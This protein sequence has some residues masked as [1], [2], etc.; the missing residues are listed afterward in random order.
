MQVIRELRNEKLDFWIKHNLNVLLIG[1]YGAGKTARIL[2]AFKRNNLKFKYFSAAT[3]DPWCDF[4]GIP[5]VMTDEN[6]AYLDYILP[7][8][9]RDDTIEAIYMDE[10]NRSHKKV[11]NAVME[12][13]QFKTINGRPFKNLKMIWAAI[14]PEEEGEYQVEPID[15]AQKDRFQVQIGVPYEPSLDY[16]ISKFEEK[17]ARAAISWWKDLTAEQQM[18]VS[19]R[20]LEYA[21]EMYNLPGGSIKDVLP[22]SSNP[23]KLTTTLKLGP[24][25]DRLCE[26]FAAND[27]EAAKK[28]LQIE[29]NYASGSR[30]FCDDVPAKVNKKDWMLFYLAVI[31]S[32]KLTALMNVNETAFN[33][34]LENCGTN[35]LFK[36]IINDILNTGTDKRLIKRI[37]KELRTNQELLTTLDQVSTVADKAYFGKKVSNI[38]WDSR[39]SAWISKPMDTTPNRVAIYNEILDSLPPNLTQTEAVNTLE[40]LSLIASRSHA[41][42]LKK[43]HHLV[44]A[45]NHCVEQ[46]HKASGLSWRE[47]LTNYGTKFGKLL[48]KLRDAKMDDKVLH[49]VKKVS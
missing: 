29:N 28:F 17:Q 10:F 30:H 45:V 34:V 31:S 13:L 25:E 9:M 48:T 19:P 46:I 38:P 8:D 18:E 32:E 16:F 4:I 42:T 20:R 15:K 24:I 2:E 12:L 41:H 40:L 7:R 23:T 43:Y 21:L 6:G 49:P 14:N 26:L 44:G 27:S 37:K 11:R 33:F 3:M 5:K 47:I 1:H 22:H 35:P 39:I 36:R